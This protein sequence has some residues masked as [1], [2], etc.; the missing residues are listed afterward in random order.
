MPHA[1]QTQ[2]EFWQSG[3]RDP[4]ET[5]FRNSEKSGAADNLHSAG[6]DTIIT[7]D[8]QIIAAY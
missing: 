1:L 2:R 7:L 5:Y 6:P 3:Q 4:L 8:P